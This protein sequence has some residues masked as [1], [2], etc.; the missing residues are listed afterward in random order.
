MGYS[1]AL[2]SHLTNM[3]PTLSQAQVLCYLRIGLITGLIDKPDLI[4]WADAEIRTAARPDEWIIELALSE[5]RSYSAIIWLLRE[6]QGSP[7]YDLALEALLARAG[8]LLA[9]EPERA[10]EIT[11]G[12]R[13][14]DEEEYLPASIREPIREM[15]VALDA[16]LRGE[17]SPAGLRAHLT[18]F[19]A[20]FR[21]YEALLEHLP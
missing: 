21:C 2:A 10:T 15:K 17:L 3:L 18:G 6:F 5:R 8:L 11:Q 12:L 13:L 4:A 7:T 1:S 14:L 16:F 20:P 9:A 19:L